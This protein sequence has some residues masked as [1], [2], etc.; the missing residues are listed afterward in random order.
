MVCLVEPT[1]GYQSSFFLLDEGQM[2][3][4]TFIFFCVVV[5]LFCSLFVAPQGHMYPIIH[6]AEKLLEA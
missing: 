6:E 1:V 5:Q 3:V 4:Q 2:Q